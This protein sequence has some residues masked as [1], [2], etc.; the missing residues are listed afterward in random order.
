M[1]VAEIAESTHFNG[2]PHTFVY[3]VYIVAV[4]PDACPTSVNMEGSVPSPGTPSTVTA[5]EQDTL[6][7]HATTVSY[8]DFQLIYLQ[9]TIQFPHFSQTCSQRYC[10]IQPKPG[11]IM[12]LNAAHNLT[13]T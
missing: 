13:I 11:Y 3:I 7:P 4:S 1:G 9:Y 5:L 6:E 2:C 12:Y 10:T 8:L